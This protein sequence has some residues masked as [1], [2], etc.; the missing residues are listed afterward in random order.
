MERKK[1]RNAKY[2]TVSLFSGIGGIDLGFEYA[3]FNVI[4]ANE[5]DKYAVETYRKNVSQTIV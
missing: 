5:F 3:G 4:W 2:K 1:I